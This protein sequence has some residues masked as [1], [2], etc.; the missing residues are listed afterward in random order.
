MGLKTLSTAL[1]TVF[2]LSYIP[3]ALAARSGMPRLSRWTGAGLLGT[4]AGLAALPLLPREPLALGAFLAASALL[5]GWI[6]AS[7]EETLGRRDDPR[8]VLD[9]VV[10]YWAAVAYLPRTASVLAASFVIFRALDAAKPPPLKRIEALPGG[11]GVMGDDL[12]A[13]IAAN[14]IV[15]I[16]MNFFPGWLS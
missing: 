9:E 3:V 15:R 10:G 13:G 16:L 14:A 4:A 1:A 7:A 2:Y 8:I 6:C 12:A 11:W 5:G